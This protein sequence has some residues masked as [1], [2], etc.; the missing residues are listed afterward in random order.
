M[1][2]REEFFNF[3]NKEW[4]EKNRGKYFLFNIGYIDSDESITIIIYY[5]YKENNENKI[6]KCYLDF[7][8]KNERIEIFNK[9]N[10]TVGIIPFEYAML[11]GDT[12]K[13]MKD[14][15]KEVKEVR[16]D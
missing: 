10:E 11:F 13:K 1:G 9:N 2:K 3:I 4:H 14:F 15:F 7:D 6:T 5:Y 16:N 8:C 12:I